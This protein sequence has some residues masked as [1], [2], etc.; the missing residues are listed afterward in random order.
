MDEELE[1]NLQGTA[2]TDHQKELAQIHSKLDVILP[3]VTKIDNRL[4]R[5]EN[6]LS[7][8]V[9]MN[10]LA[11]IGLTKKLWGLFILVLVVIGRFVY[12]FF[13][14]KSG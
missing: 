7:T 9:A 3:I 10:S 12:D 11:R 14:N 2:M 13:Q 1:D 6:S 5:D 4:F 8:Q